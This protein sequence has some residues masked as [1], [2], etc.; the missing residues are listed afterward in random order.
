[1]QADAWRGKYNTL[2]V[3][4]RI[5]TR[6]WAHIIT[7]ASTYNMNKGNPRCMNGTLCSFLC[8]AYAAPH[9]DHML[10]R[11]C[12]DMHPIL[13]HVWPCLRFA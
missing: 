1:M 13:F 10:S 6:Q 5:T 9:N 3:D 2:P 12:G 4:G 11:Q 7:R 8:G